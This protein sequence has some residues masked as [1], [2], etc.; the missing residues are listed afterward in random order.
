MG[1]AAHVAAWEEEWG[2]YAWDEGSV[3]ALG[4][5]ELDYPTVEIFIFSAWTDIT[6]YVRWDAGVTIRRGRDSEAQ[7]LDYTRCSL[8]L[9]NRDGRFSV[10]NVLGPYFGQLRINTPIRVAVQ[11]NGVTRYRFYGE[12]SEWP[13]NWD[14][15]ARDAND[16]QR[17][18][19]V[20][21]V[22]SGVIRRLTQNQEP[23]KSAMYRNITRVAAGTGD[24]VGYWPMEEPSGSVLFETGLTNNAQPLLLSGANPSAGAFDDF[25]CSSTAL[26]LNAGSMQATIPAYVASTTQFVRVLMRA[27]ETAVGS[28]QT[29]MRVITTGTARY[30][31][32][33]VD[34]SFNVRLLVQDPDEATL[35]NS[36]FLNPDPNINDRMI[37]MLLKLTTNGS[38]IDFELR[39][40]DIETPNDWISISLNEYTISSTV[41]SQTAGRIAFVQFG[42]NFG[43]SG[44]S[45]AHLVA[46]NDTAIFGEL[47]SA[48][49]SALLAYAGENPSARAARLAA[50]EGVPIQILSNGQ[51][52]NTVGM[53][54]QKPK[55]FMDLM[56]ECAETDNAL[57]FEPRDQLA[58]GYR[59]RLSLYNQSPLFELD[60]SNSDLGDVPVPVDDDRYL[61][62]DV[63]ANNESAP[64]AA[65]N[66][67][68]EKTSGPRNVNDPTTDDDGVGRYQGSIQTNLT[69]DQTNGVGATGATTTLMDLAGWAVHIGTWDEER[70]PRVQLD[71]HRSELRDDVP[72]TNKI[73]AIEQGDRYDIENMPE[74]VG[75]DDVR[76]ILQG[77]EEFIGGSTLHRITLQGTPARPWTVAFADSSFDAFFFRADSTESTLTSD[78]DSTQTS[79]S[80]T[81]TDTAWVTGSNTIGIYVGGER[82]LTSSI[83]GASS[84]Q[85]FTVTRSDNGVV[86]SHKA[87][88]VVRLWQQSTVQL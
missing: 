1:I 38:D 54:F 28:T 79:F 12:V 53:G 76:Q 73:L 85:T 19:T 4:P 45:F 29:I 35:Y 72:L 77:Y 56:R 40:A 24:I 30:W 68:H 67:R 57:L 58:I 71:L 55:T 63:F 86:K 21:L 52:G 14:R 62:N 83:A 75:P 37:A 78:I 74:W 23:L 11:R 47:T 10:R 20:E 49:A 81:V 59:T 82:M 60:Y 15:S 33:Q 80:V 44:W 42:N 16:E 84:P 5:N 6:P 27:N 13:V 31:T 2:D 26:S 17:D 51:S 64:T 3:V 65:V 50:E 32:V 22:A 70:Y 61:V 39:F 7:D 18:V 25:Y 87:G 41:T 9:D 88:T 43:L 46:V 8:T 69:T 34:T 48:G 36:G 66:V